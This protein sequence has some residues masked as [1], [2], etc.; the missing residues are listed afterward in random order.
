MAVIYCGFVPH[1]RISIIQ[2]AGFRRNNP[3]G[4]SHNETMHKHIVQHMS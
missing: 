1:Q 4:F 3:H 2:T